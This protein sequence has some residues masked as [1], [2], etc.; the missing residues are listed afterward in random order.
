[1]PNHNAWRHTSAECERSG[2]AVALVF[3]DRV[4]VDPPSRSRRQ[5]LAFLLVDL[6][7]LVDARSRWSGV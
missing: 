3:V 6:D 4:V 7:Y 2:A 5:R 1:M